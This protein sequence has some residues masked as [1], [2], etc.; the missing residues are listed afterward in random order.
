MKNYFLKIKSSTKSYL[1]AGLSELY[2]MTILVLI[3][4]E[5][6]E[7]L[8]NKVSYK[9]FIRLRKLKYLLLGKLDTMP[10]YILQVSG[11]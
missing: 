4:D 6:G 11:D 2:V 3:H 8:K 5:L 9:T 10:P 7:Y 1:N